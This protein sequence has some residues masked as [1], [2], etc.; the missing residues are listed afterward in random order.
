V[1]S[2]SNA[3]YITNLSL[4]ETSG[5]WSGFNAAVFASL[6]RHYALEYV[7]PV[8]PPADLPARLLSKVRRVAGR[9]GSFQFFSERRLE[10]V[11]KEIEHRARAD[12]ALD[13]FHGSTPWIA[14]APPVPY[15][16]YLDVCF[17]TYIS[18]YHRRGEFSPV[19]ITR[20]ERQE[21]EWLRKASRVFFSSQWALD[22]AAQAYGLDRSAFATVGLGGHVPIPSADSY[23]G[24]HEFLFMALDFAGK[25]GEVCVDA[26]R[27]VRL[28]I[29]DATLRIVG[30]EPPKNVVDIPGVMYEGRLDK[31]ISGE[32][33][34][35]K[36]LFTSAFALVHPTVKDATPQVI[37]EAAY[38]GCPVIAP[39]SF[40]IP[41]MVIDGVTGCLVPQPPR[42]A[43]IAERM[44]WL[45]QHPVEYRQMRS[46]ARAGVLANF[47]WEQ[48][49]DRM[50]AELSSVIA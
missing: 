43:T 15:A 44:L 28:A 29:P 12:V 31:R 39:R 45:L 42:A 8:S 32:M 24:G 36:D 9:P 14:Y 33:R 16:C 40:G 30:A 4:S 13:F 25:G 35:L 26:F 10:R 23:S 37:I 46:A 47:T 11:A 3:N 17:S 27:Q 50:A 22:E 19:D 48:V 2:R 6:A 49:G 5:G 7:G 21:A 20:I 41:D 38:H 18:V 34:R 1:N